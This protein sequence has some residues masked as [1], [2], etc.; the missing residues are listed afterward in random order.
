MTEV[1]TFSSQDV[2]PERDAVLDSQGIPAGTPLAKETEALY[3]AALDVLSEIAEPAGILLEVSK[4]D[5]AAVYEGEGLNEPSTPVGDIFDRGGDLAL[6]AV[7]LGDRVSREIEERFKGN[8][9]AVGCMLDSAASA[10]A[11]KAAEAAEDRYFDILSRSGRITPAT[12]VLRYS[13]GYCG[14]HMSGQKTLFAFLHPEQIGVSLRE[15]FLMEPLK[16]ISGV[17]IAGP[18]DIHGFADSYPFCSRC[19]T[20]GCRERIR[21]LLGE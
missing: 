10:A 2:A 13:P 17:M 19:E 11:D 21:A 6:F 18:R 14:W 8:D 7:T 4:S 9:F 16:S 12:R 1:L 3:I 20:R 5:F 15:S